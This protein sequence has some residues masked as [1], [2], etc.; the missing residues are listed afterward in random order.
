VLRKH[1]IFVLRSLAAIAVALSALLAYFLSWGSGEPQKDY[2]WLALQDGIPQGFVLIEPQGIHHIGDVIKIRFGVAYDPKGWEVSREVF[3]SAFPLPSD[4][5]IHSRRIRE[6]KVQALRVLEA[7]LTVQCFTC[8]DVT[9]HVSF[10]VN[11]SLRVRNKVTGEVT[12]VSWYDSSPAIRFVPLT[13]ASYILDERALILLPPAERNKWAFPLVAGGGSALVAL[14]ILT[15][16][17]LRRTTRVPQSTAQGDSP[18]R[19]R[20]KTLKQELAQGDARF[21]AHSLYTLL[22]LYGEEQ[23]YAEEKLR[24]LTVQLEDCYSP[25]GIEKEAVAKVIER[26]LRVV[27]GEV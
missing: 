12:T 5:E 10:D 2:A 15:Y 23:G 14:V 1:K 27:G 13:D 25:K 9:H 22:L 20:L 6:R 21:V 8:R 19:A 18:Y 17:H 16:V 4:F 7:E 3:Q 26:L 24:D 11:Q